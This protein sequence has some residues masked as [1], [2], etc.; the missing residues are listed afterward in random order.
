MKLRPNETCPIHRSLSCCGREAIVK[1]RVLRP[2]VQRVEDPH[3]PRGYRELRSPGEMRKLLKRKIIEQN[4]ICPICL[5]A[6]TDYNDVV[7]DH[8]DLKGMGGAW[9][10]DHPNNVQATHWWC[11][12][13]KGSTRMDD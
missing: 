9:R 4:G 2:G 10:D 3:H 8:K 1:T 5:E 6:F 12:S 11:N 7:P 13:E